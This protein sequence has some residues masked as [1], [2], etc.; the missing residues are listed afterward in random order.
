M[1]NSYNDK[2]ELLKTIIENLSNEQVDDIYNTYLKK[3]ENKHVDKHADKHIDKH[4]DKP[5]KHVDKHV[6]KHIDKTSQK[7]KLLLELINGI[8]K[9]LNKDQ[10]NDLTDFKN[11]NRLDIIRKD[12]VIL[13]EEMT[14]K[15]FKE[16]DKSNVGYYRKGQNWVLNCLRGMCKNIGLKL[17]KTQKAKSIK[18]RIVTQFFYSIV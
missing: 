13:L 18:S 7:Y 4:I 14:N 2:K 8:L 6:D 11:I 9:N 17:Q 5:N 12:N 10:V 15:L 3:K 16:F 1:T